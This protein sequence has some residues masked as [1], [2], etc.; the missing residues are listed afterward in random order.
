VFDTLTMEMLRQEFGPTIVIPASHGSRSAE[1]RRA[2]A[3]VLPD[4]ARR[5]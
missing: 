5:P 4:V 1:D 3:G 2:T